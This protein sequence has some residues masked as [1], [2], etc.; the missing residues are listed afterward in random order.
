MESCLIGTSAHTL[1][2]ESSNADV[3]WAVR[4][5]GIWSP[6]QV[7]GIVAVEEA[8]CTHSD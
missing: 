1:F 2:L 7:T 4:C 3:R 8:D 5:E 6:G